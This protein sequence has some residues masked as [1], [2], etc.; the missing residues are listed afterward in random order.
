MEI[1]QWV[2]QCRMAANITQTE[3]GER[4][5]VS[6]GNVSAWETN[7]HEPS[8]AQMIEIAKAAKF[9]VPLPGLPAPSWPFRDVSP[10]QFALLSERE[11]GKVEERILTFI[12]GKARQ[13]SQEEA[14]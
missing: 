6:K 4:L 8:Y 12:E 9:S 11:L 5:H 10:E 7:K 14:A 2:K 3:L 1:G 13:G